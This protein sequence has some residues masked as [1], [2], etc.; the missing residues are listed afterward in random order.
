MLPP[1]PERLAVG[2]V[3][4]LE[5]GYYEVDPSQPKP[6]SEALSPEQQRIAQLHTEDIA[7]DFLGRAAETSKR[8]TDMSRGLFVLQ[9]R[10]EN[11]TEQTRLSGSKAKSRENKL[12]LRRVAK[13]HF[14]QSI[15]IETEETTS[16]RF[17]E[18]EGVTR[19]VR[20]VIA[21]DPRRQTELS[22]KYKLFLAEYEHSQRRRQA[23]R[24][25]IAQ[26]LATHTTTV[27]AV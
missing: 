24:A 27:Q 18:D 12:R 10:G 19:E 3:V 14:A 4:Q 5:Q 22:E 9:Q 11:Q 21:K 1:T 26:Q 23:R 15:G 8:I 7:L 2:A 20:I 6:G 16:A 13:T 17:V 25:E